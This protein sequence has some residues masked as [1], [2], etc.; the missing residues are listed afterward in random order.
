MTQEVEELLVKI[1]DSVWAPYTRHLVKYADLETEALMTS[2]SSVSLSS[3]DI[4]DLVQ[5]L[6]DSVDKVFAEAKNAIGR[7]EKATG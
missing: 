5:V 2:L 7:C 3:G 4:I 6:D 1:S